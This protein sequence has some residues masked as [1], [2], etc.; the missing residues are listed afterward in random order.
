MGTKSLGFERLIV[1]SIVAAWTGANALGDGLTAY[2]GLGTVYVIG[3]GRVVVKYAGSPARDAHTLHIHNANEHYLVNSSTGSTLLAPE[4]ATPPGTKMKLA[5]NNS[6]CEAVGEY[7]GTLHVI[8][9]GDGRW[10][11]EVYNASNTL[12]FE[13]LFEQMGT[14]STSPGC[15]V[16]CDRG[17]C[18]CTG[19]NCVCFCGLFGEPW[20]FHAL[21]V[22]G[23]SV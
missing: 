4:R 7:E 21:I 18:S 5:L 16:S 3:D 19:Q 10:S 12:I 2:S 14:S 6:S 8:D 23:F 15:T 13:Y 17:H 22:I 1:V 11:I 20:C 9:V